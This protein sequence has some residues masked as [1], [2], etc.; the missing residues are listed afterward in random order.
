MALLLFPM[1]GCSYHS[2]SGLTALNY[3]VHL[4]GF[5]R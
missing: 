5:D 2:D 4:F 3:E 1:I